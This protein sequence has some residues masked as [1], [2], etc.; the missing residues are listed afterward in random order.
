MKKT[1]K[2]KDKKILLLDQLCKRLKNGGVFYRGLE[3]R[4]RDGR[5]KE[6]R[7]KRTKQYNEYYVRISKK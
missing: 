3:E 2:K 5:M 1:L 6:I 7:R 4:E